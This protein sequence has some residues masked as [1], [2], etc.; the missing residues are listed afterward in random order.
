MMQTHSLKTLTLAVVALAWLGGA[1]GQ[2]PTTPA[3]AEPPARVGG[4]AESVGQGRE[5]SERLAVLDGSLAGMQRIEGAVARG[6]A[7]AVG[8]DGRDLADPEAPAT[9]D[10]DE[11][12]TDYWRDLRFGRNNFE[13]VRDFVR[14]HYL[15]DTIDEHR[16]WIEAA[17]FALLSQKPPLEILPDAFY[18]ARKGLPEEEGRLDG[19]I[20]KLR[21]GDAFVVHWVPDIKKPNRRLE[22]EEIRQRKLKARARHALIEGET[23]GWKAV[24]FTDA[25]FER[26]LTF[27]RQLKKDDP[28]FRADSLYVD[29]ANGYLHS[30]DPHSS[31]ISAKSWEESTRETEDASFDGIG[32]V[33]TQRG[34]DTYVESPIEGQPA[35]KAGVR[36]GDIVVRVD[37]KEVS[38]LPLPKV[39]K[40]I[41][42]PRGTSVVL[43]LRRVGEP[44]D[45]DVSIARAH[46]DIKNVQGHLITGHPTL[47]YIKMNGFVPSS[48]DMFDAELERLQREAKGR[49]RGIVFDLRNNSGGLLNQGVQ[50][51]DKFLRKGTIVTV[52]DR[53]PLLFLGERRV[54]EEPYL[55][56][57][58][59][60]VRLPV[61]VLVNDGTASAAEIVASALQDNRRALVIGDRTFGKGSVQTLYDAGDVGATCRQDSECP[62]G[63]ACAAS[64]DGSAARCKDYYIK[65]TVARYYAPSGRSI[66]ILGVVPDVEVPPDVGGKMPVGFREEDLSNPLS[67][68]SASQRPPFASDGTVQRLEACVRKSGKA[69]AMHAADPNPA[70]KFDYPL[71]K[72]ADYLDCLATLEGQAAAR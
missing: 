6:R 12:S 26:V 56:D 70:I 9:E 60:P 29:A 45:F 40:R 42:G 47:G 46:I 53:P 41:R 30:L 64:G 10:D 66:Q 7:P 32:A 39:V 15:D 19:K 24:P 67:Q 54:R 13:E 58:A 72:A 17:D 36:A 8:S 44:K 35:I 71:Y 1:C 48:S 16:A 31:L 21:P 62:A 43:T 28:K 57:E 69:E 52:K 34:D 61:V 27:I 59:M 2:K 65:L 4:P 49:L 37:G 23:L 50:V 38:G 55:A 20:Q 3:P 51:A 33:L 18:N 25:D 14:R 63:W 11:P 5:A 68:V 22:D